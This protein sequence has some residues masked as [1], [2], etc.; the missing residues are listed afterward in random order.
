MTNVCNKIIYVNLLFC[1]LHWCWFLIA[2]NFLTE[3]RSSSK[4]KGI[5][6]ECFLNHFF[7][8]V[9]EPAYQI[10]VDEIEMKIRLLLYRMFLGTHLFDTTLI[11]L[12]ASTSMLICC[13]LRCSHR[14]VSLFL[15]CF[16]HVFG[17]HVLLDS[18]LLFIWGILH[19]EGLRME[20]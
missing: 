7:Q 1:I 15:R 12:S 2:A 10:S 4:S 11:S 13:I 18:H 5:A 20:V 6:F 9:R 19:V 3:I 17:C 14:I 8:D 16:L